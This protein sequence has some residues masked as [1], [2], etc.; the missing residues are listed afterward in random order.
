ME[1]YWKNYKPQKPPTVLPTD[2]T[3]ADGDTGSAPSVLSDFDRYRLTL[4]SNRDREGWE[5]ELRRYE[6]DMPADVTSET[7]IV[8]WWQVCLYISTT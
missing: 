6:S 1:K 4:L 7:D 5:A 8:M 2:V 3:N